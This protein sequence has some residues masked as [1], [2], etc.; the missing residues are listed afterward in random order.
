MSDPVELC[1]ALL[2]FSVIVLMMAVIT[3]VSNTDFRILKLVKSLERARGR[4]HAKRRTIRAM[5][6]RIAAQ[7]ELLSKKA[8][9]D[10]KDKKVL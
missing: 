6:D 5:A 10:G 2:L 3:Y 9:K 8:N 7:A 4:L 1:T